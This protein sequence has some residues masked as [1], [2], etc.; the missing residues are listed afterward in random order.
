MCNNCQFR[1]SRGIHWIF[2]YFFHSLLRSLQN[3]LSACSL[4]EILRNYRATKC[5]RSHICDGI[6]LINVGIRPIGFLSESVRLSAN[7]AKTYPI[8]TTFCDLLLSVVQTPNLSP[9]VLTLTTAPQTSSEYP[10]K[11]SPIMHNIIS[12]QKWSRSVALCFFSNCSSHL[13][14]RLFA[15]SSHIGRIPCLNIL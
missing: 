5:Q 2:R 4:N 1:R 13:P 9:L 11:A 7:L 15:S 14:P 10:L 3:I 6:N 12:S 8:S